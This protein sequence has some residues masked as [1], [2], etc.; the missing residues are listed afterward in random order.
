MGEL[1]LNSHVQEIILN[2]ERATGVRLANGA[3]I[4]AKRAVI[5]GAS[6]WDTLKL[7]PLNERS[8]K[9]LQQLHQE[10][11]AIPVCPSF[12]HLHLG[13]EA[14]D[15]P[16]DLPC[17][18][19]VVNDWKKEWKTTERRRRIHAIGIRPIPSAHFKRQHH[20]RIL[21]ASS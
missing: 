11:Q 10:R 1:R 16:K 21:T 13:I 20:R 12:M 2:G 18:W 4:R 15:L 5:S 6:I 17:H 3:I 8:P 19:L 7:L 9:G 14:S